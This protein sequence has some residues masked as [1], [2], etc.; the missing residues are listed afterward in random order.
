MDFVTYFRERLLS[1]LKNGKANTD[2]YSLLHF[3]DCSVQ[4]I[5][6]ERINEIL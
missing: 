3:S 5:E 2:F 1:S 6:T 4:L